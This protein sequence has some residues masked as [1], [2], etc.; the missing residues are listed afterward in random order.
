MVTVLRD[1]PGVV[2]K[3]VSLSFATVMGIVSGHAFGL[4]IAPDLT[5]DEIKRSLYQKAFMEASTKDR[6]YTVPFEI[7][8]ALDVFAHTHIPA[9][10][11]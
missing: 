1:R 4:N 8:D 10:R 6:W 11:S 2:V 3:V 9:R 5:Q 7:S